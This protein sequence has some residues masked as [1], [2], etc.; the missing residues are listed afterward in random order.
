MKR[1]VRGPAVPEARHHGRPAAPGFASG[2]V[3]TLDMAVAERRAGGDREQE[4]TALRAAVVKAVTE[5]SALAAEADDDAAGIL[6]F[7]I[8]LLEDDALSEPAF[9]AIASGIP[10]DA[11]WRDALDDE[12]AGYRA[13]EDETFHAR[14]ADLAD[15]R[16]RVLGHLGAG[17]IAPDVTRGSIVAATDLPPSRFLAIDWRAGGAVLL[18][19]G[20]RNSHVAMLARARGVPMIVGLGIDPIRLAG[21]AL[22]D[23]TCGELVLDPAPATRADFEARRRS[24]EH[25]A[26]QAAIRIG[27]PAVTADGVAV[28]VHINVASPDELASLSPAICDGIGLVRTEFLFSG[29]SLPDEEAQYRVYRRLAEWSNGKP[30]TIRTLDAGGD[31]PVVGLTT[32]GESNPFL[33]VRGVRLSLS[34][35]D[36]FAVQLRALA[37]AACHG[38]VRIMLPMVTLPDEL[39]AARALLDKEMAA[40]RAAGV[41]AERPPLGIMVEVPAAA[42]AIERFDAAFFSVGSNDLTQYVTA[43]GRDIAAVADLA[44]PLNAAVLR[45]IRLVVEHGHASGREVSLCGDAG[46]DPAA[47]EALLRTGLRSL[48]VAPAALAATKAAIGRTDLGQ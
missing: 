24:H 15:L 31:K 9:A 33:G 48:S 7:Q 37:R 38:K 11:A 43:A 5:L 40:L 28:A 4:M 13:G 27:D 47:I 35:P 1:R 46:G 30:V 21:E 39:E 12:I 6:G 8:A 42:L 34:Y 25:G 14:A 2:R 20:S 10:A 45:L 17:A 32:A 36:V 22:V 23:A 41:A 19:E 26:T 3:V 29:G 18:S 16:D 44:D